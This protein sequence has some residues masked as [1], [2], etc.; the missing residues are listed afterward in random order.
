MF[1]PSH[2]SVC[3]TVIVAS[4]GTFCDCCGVAIDNQDCISKADQKLP[5]KPMTDASA[6]N[7]S[8]HWVKGR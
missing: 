5:C 4:S 1:Q 2:C 3:E 6:P 7:T 8:H